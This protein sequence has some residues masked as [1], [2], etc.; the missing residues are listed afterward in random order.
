MTGGEL[1]FWLKVENVFSEN[2]AKLYAA[3]MILALEA[4]HSYDCV[5][6]DLKPENVL[7]DSKGHVRLTDFGLCKE[8]VRAPG[9]MQG[10]ESDG[11]TH[12]FCGTPEYLAP[13]ILVNKGHGKAVD[14]WSLGTLFYEMIV[15][16]PPFYDENKRKMYLKIMSAPLV[17]PDGPDNE[18]HLTENV[19]NLLQGLLQRKVED[20]LGSGT[21][22]AGEIKGHPF[23]ADLDFGK[24]LR[25]KYM[26]EFVPP[27]R[28]GSTDVCN[29]E[30]R[31]TTEVPIDSIVSPASRMKSL[32]NRPSV[33]DQIR[34]SNFSYDQEQDPMASLASETTMA[35]PSM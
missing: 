13:E 4:L 15:G 18:L 9:I 11:T 31:F 20:R 24:V 22:G 33:I 29:F 17:F 8:Q 26:P 28:S 12:T 3:E 25:K 34:F 32:A 27:N 10:S 1:F 2:R 23:F 35:A 19:K 14:W 21:T 7:L 16:L 5:Y 6:R 30:L